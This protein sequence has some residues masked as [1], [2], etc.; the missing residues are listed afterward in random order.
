MLTIYA[1]YQCL[2]TVLR[3]GSQMHGILNTSEIL[4]LSPRRRENYSSKTTK[5]IL[6]ENPDGLTVSQVSEKTHITRNTTAKHLEMLVA[7]REA[8]K[9]FRKEPREMGDIKTAVYFP[10]G[11][12]GKGKLIHCENGTYRFARL[13]NETGK[14]VYVKEIAFDD[15]RNELVKGVLMIDFKNF[16]TFTKELNTFANKVISDE[17]VI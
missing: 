5:A 4:R 13:E 8:R 10:I 7:K 9:E 1:R 12:I 17:P 14:Y 11:A 16:P 6:E 3:I 15:M 2:N